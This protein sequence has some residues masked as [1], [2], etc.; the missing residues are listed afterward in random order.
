MSSDRSPDAPGAAAPGGTL[1]APPKPM[2][3]YA[4]AVVHGGF[5]W[6]AGMTPRVD[7][8]LVS[9]GRLGAELDVEAG[10]VAAHLAARNA[11]AAIGAAIGGLDRVSAVLQ[12][13]VYVASEPEFTGHSA[14]AD[15]ASAA[16]DDALG[17]RGVAARAAI[18]VASLPGGAP[19][20]VTI[21]VA[22]AR[23]VEG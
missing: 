4:P 13:T 22:H 8:A 18:G 2:G 7:G 19:V 16:L 11:L 10:R 23:P 6:S 20:E 14:V 3:A 1:P 5:A 21:S 9:T 12:L 15:G 17:A